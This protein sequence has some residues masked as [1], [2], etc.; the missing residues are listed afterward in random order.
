M[1][2]IKFRNEADGQEFQMTHPKAARVLSDI[3]TWAQRNAFEHVA[4]WRDPEDQHKL[5]VQLGDDRLNYWIHDSTFTE[6]KHET[7]EMQMDYARGAQR[8]S[9]AGYGKFDK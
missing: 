7:V 9:A 6:G 1:V 8:R 5:W 3:Q 2:E 4:F